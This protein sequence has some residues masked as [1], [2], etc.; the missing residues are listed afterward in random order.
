MLALARKALAGAYGSSIDLEHVTLVADTL[1][2]A[3]LAVAA[4]RKYYQN[5]PDFSARTMNQYP[6]SMLWNVPYSSARAHPGFKKL[7]IETGV[8]DYWRQT[9]KWGDG[10]APV[11]ADDFE[12]R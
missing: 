2:D 6:Y 12:C 10:C 3:D 9:G 5:E 8:A 11:G 4:L 1:G 7:L